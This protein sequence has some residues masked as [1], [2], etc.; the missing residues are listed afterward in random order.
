MHATT[1]LRLFV[2]ISGL[3]AGSLHASEALR[4]RADVWMPFN[5]GEG[6]SPGYVTE[7]L[8]AIFKPKGVEVQ[9]ET[10]AW[11]KSLEGCREGTVD[12]VPCASAKEAKGLT[13]P[14][15]PIADMVYGMF[16]LKSSAWTLGATYKNQRIGATP[17]YSYWEALDEFLAANPASVVKL[18][19]EDP[20]KDGAQKLL[21]K[22]VDLVPECPQVFYWTVKQAGLDAS[23]F[24]MAC[25]MPTELVYVAFRADAKG[26]EW[27][28]IFDEG[29]RQLRKSGELAKIL[30]KYQVADWK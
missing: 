11:E 30:A 12:A 28:R 7:V 8:Q 18:S 20:C 24:K 6:N 9:Y 27:A 5:G 3:L 26:K 29:I 4:V 1:A 10:L 2:V 13:L 22:Q 25:R 19:E 15:E 23:Q 21:A 17:G 16:A 14:E